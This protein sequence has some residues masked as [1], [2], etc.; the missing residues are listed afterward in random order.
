MFVEVMGLEF[1]F[2]CWGNGLGT[3][4][5]QIEVTPSTSNPIGNIPGRSTQSSGRTSCLDLKVAWAV[6]IVR[7]RAD[8]VR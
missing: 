8:E 4:N 1:L 7:T 5:I 6:L 3:A 2:A